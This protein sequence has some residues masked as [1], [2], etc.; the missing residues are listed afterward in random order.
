M[1]TSK[2]SSEYRNE[3]FS[4]ILNGKK[5]DRVPEKMAATT[6]ATYEYAGFDLRYCQYGTTKY[7]EAIDKINAD[8]DTDTMLGT[9]PPTPWLFRLINSERMTMVSDGFLQHPDIHSMEVDEYDELIENPVKFMWDKALPRL[10]KVLAEPYPNNVLAVVKAIKTTDHVN[11]QIGAATRKTSAKYN[12]VT[13]PMTKA[14]GGRIPADFLADVLR[15]F[16]GMLIDMKRK[17]DK[18][19]EAL[20][21]L[22][23]IFVGNIK[24]IDVPDRTLRGNTMTH[25]PTFMKP[26]EFGK[27]YWPG[28]SGVQ[29]ARYDAGYSSYIFCEDNWMPF[30]DY[31][32]DLPRCELHFEFGDPKIIKE[33]LGDKHLISGLF[34]ATNLKTMSAEEACDSAKELLDIMAPGGNYIFSFDK[35]ILRAREIDWNVFREV[36]ECVHEYGKY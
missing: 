9:F 11:A 26:A 18:V 28:F 10:N 2:Y 8:F 16:K 12:K 4:N 3:L 29:K 23:E 27:F 7:A 22:T 6:T 36:N 15:S 17:P 25:M 30:L 5:T 20:D 32:Q 13:M 34:T 21:A 19:L 1:A 35:S 14:D 31:L 24:K 33:K